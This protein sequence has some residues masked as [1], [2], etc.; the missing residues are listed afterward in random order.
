MPIRQEMRPKK[1]KY[2]NSFDGS[3]VLMKF[4]TTVSAGMGTY[5]A[6]TEDTMIKAKTDDQ[7]IILEKCFIISF[8]MSVLVWLIEEPRSDRKKFCL[9]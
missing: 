1:A 2:I 9:I 7:M 4:S 3:I 5:L 6:A 8:P